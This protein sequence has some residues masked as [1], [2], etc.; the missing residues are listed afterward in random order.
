MSDHLNVDPT[1]LVSA[2]HR[3]DR[4]AARLADSVTVTAP[5]LVVNRTG[6]DEVSTAAATAF[7]SVGAGFTDDATRGVEELRK[8]AAVLRAQAAAFTD[9]E[10][11]ADAALRI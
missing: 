9:V 7:T 3:L 5:A 2:A 1:Q 6:R 11:T 4:L 8:I 10:D